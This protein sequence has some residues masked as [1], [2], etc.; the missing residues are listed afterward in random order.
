[1][2]LR[3]SSR[4]SDLARIQAYLVGAALKRV[5]PGLEIEYRFRESLGDVNQTDPLWKMPERG[6]FTEDF[7]ADLTRGETDLVVH[8]WK[9]LP[10]EERAE[11]EIVATLPRA[12]ARDL[13]L[14][15]KSAWERVVRGRKLRVFSSSPR[16]ARNLSGFLRTHLPTDITSVEFLSVRGNIATRVRKLFEDENVDAL[17]VAKAAIDRLLAPGCEWLESESDAPEDERAKF[18]ASAKDLRAR[19]EDLR[20]MVLPLSE[21]PSAAAQGA[22]AIEVK[23]GRSDLRAILAKIHSEETAACVRK[24]R[25][26]LK[27]YGGGCHQKIGI[28]VLK[29]TYGE[30]LFLRGVTDEGEV[31]DE[32]VLNSREGEA[33]PI[34]KSEAWPLPNSEGKVTGTGFYERREIPITDEEF[35]RK[36]A[37]RGLW[38]AR[39]NALPDSVNVDPDTLVWSAGL[40]TWGRLA[41]LGVWVNGSSEGLGEDEAPNIDQLAGEVV[42]WVRLSHSGVPGLPEPPSMMETLPTYDL[43]ASAGSPSLVGKRSF[44][45]MSGSAF[46]A[47]LKIY[48][49]LRDARHASGAGRTHSILRKI[50]GKEA[51]I[52]VEL[53]YGAWLKRVRGL[54]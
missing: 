24:E 43:L 40:I 4:Q 18:L 45:W 1:M 36:V 52:D 16:R 30:I 32:S 29:R 5:E 22:L 35:K 12:D 49:E 25:E 33:S 34:E 8:S 54:S 15:K 17:I 46:V 44:Y 13:L 6:V 38:I 26:I 48:P 51:K 14:L 19:L 50:L 28:S 23:K 53:N 7:L 20:W 47:A 10:V 42:Q 27:S 11:T 39:G 41:H 21:N 37:G 9:D 2:R 3:I 31:L